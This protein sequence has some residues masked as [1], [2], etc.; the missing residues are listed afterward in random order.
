[1]FCDSLDVTFDILKNPN[2]YLTHSLPM[3]RLRAQGQRMYQIQKIWHLKLSLYY[4]NHVCIILWN[5]IQRKGGGRQ[6]RIKYRRRIK[7]NTVEVWKQESRATERKRVG[8]NK[9][10]VRK[11]IL[12]SKWF[13]IESQTLI[14]EKR[15]HPR[16]A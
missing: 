13:P 3:L 2:N 11:T 1:M 15:Y 9:K 10:K 16:F 8:I 6:M 7:M 5:T 12:R 14:L 4:I